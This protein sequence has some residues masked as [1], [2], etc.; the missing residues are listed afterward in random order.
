MDLMQEHIEQLE[1]DNDQLKQEVAYLD[2]L[3]EE[4]LEIDGECEYEFRRNQQLT[5]LLE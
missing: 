3:E 5:C 1:H 4:K 2:R